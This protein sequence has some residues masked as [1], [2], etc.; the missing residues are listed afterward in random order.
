[1]DARSHDGRCSGSTGHFLTLLRH[2]RGPFPATMHILLYEWVTGGGLVQQSGKLPTSL[3]VEGSAMTAALAADFAQIPES[4]VSVLRDV[5]LHDLSLPQ[6]DIVDVDSL[7][8]WRAEFDQIA[9]IA[10][11]TMIIAPEFD[12]L[13]RQAVERGRQAG[14][15]LLNAS[16]EFVVL[17]GDKQSAA[18]QLAAAGVPTPRAAVIDA[19][20]A[21]LPR[22][23]SYPAVI[24]PRDGAGSQHM[25]LVEGPDDEPPPYPWPRRIEEF[26]PGRAASVAALCGSAGPIWLPPCWQDLSGDGRFTYRGGAII[27]D[28]HLAARAH[29]LAARAL[30]ALPP[31]HGFVGVDLVLGDCPEG[32][33]DVVIEINPRLTTSYVGLRRAVAENLATALIEACLG[34]S[35]VVTLADRSI[36]FSSDGRTWRAASGGTGFIG[37]TR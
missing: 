37:A 21:R 6:C 34:R 19:D 10:D 16:D 31:A 30:A 32:G 2:G 12:G 25:L 7:E 20:Q 27:S 23:F 33:A 17:T 29:S 24:K 9:A 13:L 36:E 3:L 18:E 22:D 4:R 15:N 26:C 1:M 35:P 11:H 28:E 8:A 5:R 14:G